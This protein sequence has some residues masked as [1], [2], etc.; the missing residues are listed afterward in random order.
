MVVAAAALELEARQEAILEFIQT[1]LTYLN[2]LIII[3]RVKYFN[4]IA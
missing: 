3:Q 2:R 1:E 4:F